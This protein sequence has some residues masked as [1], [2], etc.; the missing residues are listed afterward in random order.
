[1]IQRLGSNVLL[2]NAKMF[3]SGQLEYFLIPVKWSKDLA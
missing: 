1:M 3:S 2:L